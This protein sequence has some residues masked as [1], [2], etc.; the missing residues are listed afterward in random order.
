MLSCAAAARARRGARQ[1]PSR[2]R[3]AV[4]SP[5]PRIAPRGGS[6]RRA[7]MVAHCRATPHGPAVRG[8]AE[9]RLRGLERRAGRP[10]ARAS[11]PLP[12]HARV[13]IAL[14]RSERAAQAAPSSPC[15]RSALHPALDRRCLHAAA[16][17]ACCPRRARAAARRRVRRP[18]ARALRSALFAPR[19]AAPPAPMWKLQA[20]AG[21]DADLV[22]LNG[23][24]APRARPRAAPAAAQG[25]PQTLAAPRAKG[26]A[27]PRPP[28]AAPRLTPA[29]A[30]APADFQGRQ[31][32]VYDPAA[33]TRAERAAVESARAAYAAGRAHTHHS[34]DALL[35]LQA[36]GARAARGLPPPPP[37]PAAAKLP[38]KAPPPAATVQ[39]AMRSGLAFYETLQADDG[40]FPGD[41]GGPMFLMPGLV[42]VCHVTGVMDQVLP[43]QHRTEM[44]RYLVNH[45]NEDGGCAP[46]RARR[47]RA[48]IHARQGRARRGA[49]C[50]AGASAC[51]TCAD[52]RCAALLRVC[53]PARPQLRAA[54]RGA[55]Y[56][57]RDG[58]VVRHA[59]A[60]GRGA[61]A[62]HRCGCAPLDARPRRRH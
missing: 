10:R 39:G 44:I 12:R 56:D 8:V 25:P 60:A 6:R 52:S 45:A 29:P 55:Q 17:R 47:P 35:R 50:S 41:Y 3:A 23:A 15:A 13:P 57:V 32:W 54:H 5:A 58:A 11:P 38:A 33:G 62:R 18:G 40:H 9:R 30:A 59:A 37:P 24:A 20:A 42:I 36:A 19:R 7:F 14:C 46:R 61:V 4:A 2:S 28:R 48:R 51:E 49:R 34:S 26:G 21:G 1:A 22:T 27:Q 31:T 16:C 53:A 43:P